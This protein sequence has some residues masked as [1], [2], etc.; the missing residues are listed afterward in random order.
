MNLQGKQVVIAG[1]GRSAVGAAKLLL[2]QG[3]RPFVS[4]AGEAPPAEFAEALD[5][6]GVPCET[7]G[8]TTARFQ[9]AALVVL[10]P[11]VP[12]SIAPAQAAR[13]AGIPVLGELELAWRHCS[14]PVLAVTG[15]NGKT[16]TTELV[17]A[18]LAACG[19]RVALAGNNALPFSEAVLAEE[20]PDYFVLEVSSYQLESADAFRPWIGAVLNLTPDHLGRHGTMEE[21]A[22]V[23]ARMFQQQ[24]LGDAA[25][26]NEDDPL[27]SAMP[28]PAETRRVGFSLENWMLDGVWIQ[29]QHIKAG[30]EVV[31]GLA[32]VPLPGRHNMQNV[33][34]A[35][36]MMHAGRFPW[37]P[38][39]EGLRGFRGV[40]HRI[41]LVAEAEGVA[42]FNDSKSTNIDSLRVALESFSVPLVLIAGGQGKGNGY[43]SLRGLVEARV[44]RLIVLGE[45]APRLRRDLAG[46]AEISGA[47]DMADAVAQAHATARSGEVVLLSPGCA[48]FDMYRNFEARGRDFKT[49]VRAI[50]E[51][52]NRGDGQ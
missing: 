3:A 42:W 49:R 36:A 31:A 47:A 52:A 38:V 12:P 29:R 11:G 25:V 28:V 6:L 26:L 41:E 10:S 21:Y 30:D 27:V 34:A 35:L 2:R 24:G 23:K 48:S 43:E 45:D 13:R 16:T 4:E 1:L 7:G 44:R 19:H 40:E 17:R 32:D 15:T 51:T 14:A 9:E 39:L 22:A 8:H 50:T 33:L 5:A 18:M 46:C 20:P 37:E